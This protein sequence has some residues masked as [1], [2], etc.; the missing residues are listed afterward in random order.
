MEEDASQSESCCIYK[1]H[2]TSLPA[3][4]SEGTAVNSCRCLVVSGGGVGAPD[5][6]GTEALTSREMHVLLTTLGSAHWND[7]LSILCECRGIGNGV[8]QFARLGETVRQTHESL[9]AL[10]MW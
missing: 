10:C 1:T 6:A 5:A 8:A 4:S 9:C 7:V 3:S 2:Q